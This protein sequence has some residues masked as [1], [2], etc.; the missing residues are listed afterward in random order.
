MVS[1]NTFYC[2]TRVMHM[3]YVA[4]ISP[5]CFF[6]HWF[7]FF[8]IFIV[9]IWHLLTFAILS[10]KFYNGTICPLENTIIKY[11]NFRS[12]SY[13]PLEGLFFNSIFFLHVVKFK[14]QP[15]SKYHIHIF[16]S[17]SGLPWF[18][19]M[20]I[21]RKYWPWSFDPQVQKNNVAPLGDPLW[22]LQAQ[23]KVKVSTSF[24]IWKW[25]F[26]KIHSEFLLPYS[27]FS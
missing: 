5:F 23:Q 13:F 24:T 11:H 15:Q 7:L 4:P 22:A 25:I 18:W 3:V 8:F 26:F 16:L 21:S 27:L 1:K 10:Q 6:I 12:A 14:P 2:K 17:Q 20:L 9:I 19:F